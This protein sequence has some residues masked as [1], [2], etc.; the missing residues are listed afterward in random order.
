MVQVLPYVPSFGEKLASSFGQAAG[1]VGRSYIEGQKQQRAQTRLQQLLSGEQV[2]SQPASPM[3]S[4]NSQVQQ[5]QSRQSPLDL[6]T[7]TEI[8]N[9]G[10]AANGRG[11]GKVAYDTYIKGAELQQKS[12]IQGR[13]EEV[14]SYNL[15]K[16][17]RE[18]LLKSYEGAKTTENK[19]SRLKKLNEK[20]E[21]ASATTA[22]ISEA[23][24]IPLSILGN[25]DS[26]EFQKLSQDLLSNITETFGSRILQ[27]EV[28][29]FLKTIPTL[30]N[31]REGRE[32][33]IENM[34]LFLEPKKLAYQA[35]K[36]IRKEQGKVPLDLHEQILE[37]IEPQLDKL[38]EK[39]KQSE[40]V[41]NSLNSNNARQYKGQQAQ[42]LETGEIYISNGTEWVPLKAKDGI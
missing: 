29:N 6:N 3:D 16:D 14:E 2:T 10:E 7:A 19:L 22:K 33:I 38:S 34:E 17:Y 5:P 32:K 39:F 20:D 1:Q 18:G 30:L 42:D 37:R 9:L 13:K 41:E 28:E 27:V 8:Y 21:L 35:Y 26:E 31:S 40:G 11:G 36:D 15:T 23:L 12:D 25:P 4:L 24:G